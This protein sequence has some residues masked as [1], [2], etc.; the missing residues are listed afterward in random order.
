MRYLIYAVF[1]TGVLL[2]QLPLLRETWIGLRRRVRMSRSLRE[3]DPELGQV[4]KYGPFLGHIRRLL[5]GTGADRT[6]PGPESF[7]I[8]SALAGA[9]TAFA[10]YWK[11]GAAF[12]CGAGLFAAVCPY[13]FLRAGLT[14]RRAENSKE[15][16]ILIRELLSSYKICGKNMK[17][18]VEFTAGGLD[19]APRSKALLLEMARGF[20][21]EYT[22]E[23]IRSVL[24]DFRYSLD[25]AWSLALTTSI[26]YGHVQGAD[27]SESLED[28]QTSLVRS[29]KVA[30]DAKRENSEPQMLL[31]FLAPAV[32]VLAAVSARVFFDFPL[33]KFIR[34]Q[35]GTAI[36]LRWFV[37]CL[38]LFTAGLLADAFLSNEKMDL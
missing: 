14:S 3:L 16:D 21:Q 4:K 34:Y 10:L 27:V 1:L 29:R 30:E 31:K 19:G 2:S 20:N 23:G 15:G 28:L 25:T 24:E 33:L 6:F 32:W 8:V 12:S 36:G 22:P 17:E 13:L 5:K 9:G 11:E 35:F 38:I 7:L 18:A 37:I 26:Y